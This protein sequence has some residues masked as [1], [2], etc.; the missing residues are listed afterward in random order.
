MSTWEQRSKIPTCMMWGRLLVPLIVIM[1]GTTARCLVFLEN[2]LCIIIFALNSLSKY[3]F[4]I[5]ISG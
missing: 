3:G 5:K 2:V 4:V 1:Q